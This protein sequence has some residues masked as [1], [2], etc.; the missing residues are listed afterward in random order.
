MV[1]PYRGEVALVVDGKSYVLR[2]TLGALAE[3][4]ESLGESSLLALVERF[5]SGRFTTR[6]LLALLTSGL[7]GGGATG[8]LPNLAQAKIDGG[9]VGAARVAARLLALSFSVSDEPD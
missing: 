6:D 2:L 3:L 8:D 5:E 7:R 9:A 4:E 1:N